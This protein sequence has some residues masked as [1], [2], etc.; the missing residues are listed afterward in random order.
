MSIRNATTTIELCVP[1]S[2]VE[3]AAWI[4]AQTPEDAAD[5]LSL[6]EATAR[7]VK[8]QVSDGEIARLTAESAQLRGELDRARAKSEDGIRTAIEE[9]RRELT[10]RFQAERD[11]SCAD[12]D[13]RR[14]QHERALATLAAEKEE[15]L[16]EAAKVRLN[17]KS[18][19]EEQLSRVQGLLNHELETLRRKLQSSCD[20]LANV[21]N[22]ERAERA[23]ALENLRAAHDLKLQQLKAEN[24]SR[25]AEIDKHMNMQLSW[26]RQEL[27]LTRERLA[28]ADSERETVI[29]ESK[30]EIREMWS[31]QRSVLGGLRGSSSSVGQVGEHLV[32]TVFSALQIGIWEDTRGIANAGDGQWS[33]SG[34]GGGPLQCMVEV[35]RVA[36]L[37]TQKDVAKFWANVDTNLKA[38][39][40]NAAM[41]LSLSARVDN[42]RQLDVRMYNG[43]PVLLA[44]R[45]ADD[46]IPAAKLVELA[47]YAF[48]SLWPSLA[49][50]RGGDAEG[51]LDAVARRFNAQMEEVTQ[52]S[53]RIDSI[54]RCAQ[55]L[56]REASGLR[57][58]RDSICTGIE[59]V[60]LQYPQLYISE[61][62]DEGGEDIEKTDEWSTD[63]GRALCEAVESFRR[64]RHGRYPK[65]L[66]DLEKVGGVAAMSEE[67][68]T[69]ASTSNR[70]DKAVSLV[71]S[72]QKRKRA[73]TEAAA[74]IEPETNQDSS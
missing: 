72:S 70:L 60:R 14:V 66:S 40:I 8:C 42:A 30:N 12:Q 68:K 64:L 47:F 55:S 10:L 22:S 36:S 44:S 57:K 45:C 63:R 26:I 11:K 20:E 52:L 32:C 24:D 58:V 25:A 59:Q 21:K 43:I 51:L 38:G 35:K 5:A 53:K 62:N 46:A 71:K 69:F 16:A 50:S 28:K 56:H 67:V 15:A 73:Q 13:A 39:K 7:A 3:C 27:E 74:A 6:C 4:V 54:E 41:L 1:S 33:W 61:F 49:R 23:D 48:A 29:R 9:Q 65:T 37:H 19:H 31:Q 17:Q 18:L 2:R 34:D